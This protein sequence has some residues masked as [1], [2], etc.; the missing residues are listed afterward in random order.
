MSCKLR[1]PEELVEVSRSL[2]FGSS[3]AFSIVGGNC[4][5]QHWYSHRKRFTVASHLQEMAQSL[6]IRLVWSVS[7]RPANRSVSVSQLCVL[8]VQKTADIRTDK[9]CVWPVRL[10]IF[11][12]YGRGYTLQQFIATF[13]TVHTDRHVHLFAS[14]FGQPSTTGGGQ[15]FT[16]T[17]KIYLNFCLAFVVC[18][19]AEW[20]LQSIV[21][22]LKEQ[23]MKLSS[24]NRS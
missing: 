11:C 16:W 19:A 23:E 6:V 1:S 12:L 5:Y 17:C 24:R 18:M 14:V 2:S 9:H 8:A 4:H 15:N 10:S 7:L 20:N 3:T 22:L 13:T 21:L